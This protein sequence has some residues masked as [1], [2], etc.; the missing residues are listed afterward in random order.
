MPYIKV[1][2]RVRVLDYGARNAGELNFLITKLLL[3]Y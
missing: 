1:E 2:D 3:D